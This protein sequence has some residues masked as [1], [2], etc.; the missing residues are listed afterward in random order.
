MNITFNEYCVKFLDR[1]YTPELPDEQQSTGYLQLKKMI[2]ENITPVSLEEIKKWENNPNI[3][4]LIVTP[5]I[6]YMRFL[7]PILREY[8]IENWKTI[9]QLKI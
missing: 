7:H 8:V 3:Q 9:K 2:K 1:I 6:K 5:D 4:E